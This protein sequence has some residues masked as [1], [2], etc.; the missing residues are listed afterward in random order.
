[1]YIYQGILPDHLSICNTC[2]PTR[3]YLKIL[4]PFAHPFPEIFSIFCI[5]TQLQ[6]NFPFQNF[7][8]LFIIVG[9]RYSRKIL[10]VRQPMFMEN[11]HIQV[12]PFQGCNHI[13]FGIIPHTITHK[14]G[15]IFPV[16]DSRQLFPQSLLFRPPGCQRI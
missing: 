5:L 3:I 14:T 10:S 1:M 2:P 6:T 9:R 16:K 15:I 7:H 4:R 13:I 12:F 11:H 8:M